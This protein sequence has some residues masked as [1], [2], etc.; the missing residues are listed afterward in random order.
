MHIENQSATYMHGLAAHL[1]KSQILPSRQSL[2]SH[3][4]NE[5]KHPLFMK[6]L[7]MYTLIGRIIAKPQHKHLTIL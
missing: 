5:N 4:K 2:P 7:D 6:Y 1:F 3:P